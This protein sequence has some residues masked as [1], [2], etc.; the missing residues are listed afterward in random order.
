MIVITLIHSFEMAGKDTLT[1]LENI[2]NVRE[3]ASKVLNSLAYEEME[4]T[5]V[6][7]VLLVAHV[8]PVDHVEC[9]GHSWVAC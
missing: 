7:V 6:E 2:N 9:R 4:E 3:S 5:Y 1:P 8:G